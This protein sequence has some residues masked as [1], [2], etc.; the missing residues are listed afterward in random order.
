MMQKIAV[1]GDGITAKA[2]RDRLADFA[3]FEVSV[4][5]ADV[6][7]TS[8]GIPV[9]KFPETDKEIISEIEFSYRII[10]SLN[11]KPF[12]IGVTGTNGKSTVSALIA[13]LLQ[14]PVCGNFGVPLIHFV[15][16]NYPALVVELSSYQLETCTTFAPDVA[17][18]LNLTEDHLERHKTMEEYGRQKSKIFSKQTASQY[19]I[20]FDQDSWVKKIVG[21]ASSK[22]IPFSL[23]SPEANWTKSEVLYGQHNTLNV[24]ASVLAA[25]CYGLSDHDIQE[26]IKTFLPLEHR[27]ETVVRYKDATIINDSKATNPDSTMVAVLAFHQPIHLILCGKDKWLPLEEFV[28]FLAGKVK[29]VTVFGEIAERLVGLLKRHSENFD[30]YRCND[31]N[32]AIIHCL[33]TVQRDEVILFSPSCSSFD[34]FKDFEDRGRQFKLRMREEVF[35]REQHG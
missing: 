27:L 9:S 12:L 16:K 28:D 29:S 5:E 32:E 15:G 31:M 33:N 17:V 26:R 1:L 25:R 2:V 11:Q 13:H 24:V 30:L 6:I 3:M 35:K 10:T 22:L 8:P 34:Q 19:L 7:V 4:D 20:Y 14:V 21:G 18:F 23:K